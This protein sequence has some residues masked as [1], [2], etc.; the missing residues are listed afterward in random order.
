[1]LTGSVQVTV[2]N[3][4]NE[5]V[6]RVGVEIQSEAVTSVEVGIG[7]TVVLDPTVEMG[8]TVGLGWTVT[9]VWLWTDLLTGSEAVTVMYVE[10]TTGTDESINVG[11]VVMD[12]DGKICCSCSRDC[13]CSCLRCNECRGCGV[14]V[15][16]EIKVGAVTVV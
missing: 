7:W 11:K 6:T 16:M 5:E 8:V 14:V 1:M 3:I 15:G 10:T 9:S 4:S 12:V 2:A 13:G